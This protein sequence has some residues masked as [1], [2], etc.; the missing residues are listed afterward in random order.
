MRHSEQPPGV[1]DRSPYSPP[2]SEDVPNFRK[3]SWRA[4]SR[5]VLYALAFVILG[6]FLGPIGLVG[7][8]LYRE[9]RRRWVRKQLLVRRAESDTAL[10]VTDRAWS[11]PL[12]KALAFDLAFFFVWLA[13]GIGLQLLDISLWSLP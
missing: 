12:G 11:S 7:M 3:F 6:V 2:V 4:A 9:L 10:M 1:A 5:T 13:V 8:L